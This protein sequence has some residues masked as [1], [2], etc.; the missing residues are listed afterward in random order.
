[1]ESRKRLASEDLDEIPSTQGNPQTQRPGDW[2][3]GRKEAGGA[4]E[5]GG[6]AGDSEIKLGFVRSLDFIL[7]AW[8]S[9]ETSD[10][11]SSWVCLIWRL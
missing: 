4:G 9:T 5:A 1:M 8:E 2:K 3:E 6:E 10:L 11:S 7:E